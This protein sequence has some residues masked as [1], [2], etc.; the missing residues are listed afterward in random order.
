M[1]TINIETALNRL[2]ELCEFISNFPNSKL[3]PILKKEIAYLEKE[4]E[5][6]GC[7]VRG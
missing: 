6:N 7:I 1:E 3:V 4:L 2:D 5:T